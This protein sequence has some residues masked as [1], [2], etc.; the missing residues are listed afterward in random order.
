VDLPAD[1]SAAGVAGL[2][3]CVVVVAGQATE[4]ALLDAVATVI[5]GTAIKVANRVT[6]PTT[7]SRADFVLPESRLGARAAALGTRP[8]GA[9]GSA[10]AALADALEAA[11]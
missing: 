10:I 7:W 2:A 9:L 3:D 8:L 4:P 5:G 6:D 1:G 11:R